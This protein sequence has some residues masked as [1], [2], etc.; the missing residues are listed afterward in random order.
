[1]LPYADEERTS[2]P[3]WEEGA[4]MPVSDYYSF[5]GDVQLGRDLKPFSGRT[6]LGD[7]GYTRN[8]QFYASQGTNDVFR[9]EG[10]TP[11]IKLAFWPHQLVH[12]FPQNPSG[13][14]PTWL[15]PAGDPFADFLLPGSIS[16]IVLP[17]NRTYAWGVQLNQS[18]SSSD[19][20]RQRW[21]ALSQQ[22]ANNSL[23]IN[24]VH[25]LR[26]KR[27]IET[28]EDYSV[29]IWEDG[30][31]FSGMSVVRYDLP[32]GEAGLRFQPGS[33]PMPRAT[34]LPAAVGSYQRNA[35]AARVTAHRSFGKDDTASRVQAMRNPKREQREL[36]NGQLSYESKYPLTKDDIPRLDHHI[37]EMNDEGIA[38]RN[39]FDGWTEP[40]LREPEQVS[41]AEQARRDYDQRALETDQAYE[42][43]LQQERIESAK[44][45][46]SYQD[47]ERYVQER[48]ARARPVSPNQRNSRPKSYPTQKPSV[49]RGRETQPIRTQA[50]VHK[51]NRPI[52]DKPVVPN[53]S[54]APMAQSSLL[55]QQRALQQAVDMNNRPQQPKRPISAPGLKSDNHRPFINSPTPRPAPKPFEELAQRVNFENSIPDREIYADKTDGDAYI[56]SFE[57]IEGLEQPENFSGTL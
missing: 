51:P 42:E 30:N 24:Y 18:V 3:T 10:S 40:H 35:G 49:T 47:H 37:V 6:W 52:N 11:D 25:P 36:P 5:Q 13:L 41:A 2:H 56:P 45:R 14:Q 28:L 29:L 26:Q 39:K 17:R 8:A 53:D 46:A 57:E 31:R 21:Y 4:A 32:A 1:V 27:E 22:Q 38:L 19:P 12:Q 34:G 55:D 9:F 50:Y 43:W 44:K 23:M 33:I 48:V 7:G 20:I 16:T 54:A 15:A